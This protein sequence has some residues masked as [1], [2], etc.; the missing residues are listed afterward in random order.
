MEVRQIMK[1][2]LDG[3]FLEVILKECAANVK[4]TYNSW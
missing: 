1:N 3:G 4:I 2:Q